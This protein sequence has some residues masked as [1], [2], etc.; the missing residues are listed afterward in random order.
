MTTQ[1][2]LYND[3]LLAI[4]ERKIASLSE[5]REP[6]RALDDA[7]SDVDA[8][9]YCLE[10]GHW[11]FA[12]RGTLMVNSPSVTPAFGYAYAFEKPTDCVK[13]SKM[14]TDEY[15]NNPLLSYVEEAGWWYSNVTDIYISYVSDDVLYGRD[16][17]KWP[18]SFA[19]YVGLYL[20]DKI[21]LRITQNQNT[22]N[23][24]EK[25]VI[26]ALFDAKNKD[27]LQGPTVF[28]PVGSWNRARG[29]GAR[30]DRGNRGS[31]IG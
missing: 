25:D 18:E 12:Q 29:G 11:K 21:C 28:P 22:K 8:V 17:A 7:Y 27:A 1:L 14:C 4:G 9:K 2:R 6:R 19:N 26:R 10:Q 16:L 24:L 30:G 5:N 20:A 23:R 31:L 13:I 15:F 3:A